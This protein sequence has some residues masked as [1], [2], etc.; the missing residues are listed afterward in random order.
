MYERIKSLEYS[1]QDYAF[2]Y[3]EKSEVGDDETIPFGLNHLYQGKNLNDFSSTY[4]SSNEGIIDVDAFGNVSGVKGIYNGNVK[5]D[6][7][8]SADV[9]ATI[10]ATMNQNGQDTF[11]KDL[12]FTKTFTYTG[13]ERA[14]PT[15]LSS[16]KESASFNKETRE[17]TLD[18]N[19]QFQLKSILNLPSSLTSITF[20]SSDDK[21]VSTTLLSLSDTINV[22]SI[23]ENSKKV[24][25]DLCG[26][27][28]T[29]R[30]MDG[31]TPK[32]ETLVF[33]IRVRKA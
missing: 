19:A 20:S 32:K 7:T 3:A 26:I 8:K 30:Y 5:D 9:E 18:E 29:V 33:Y 6:N 12:S 21:L 24:Q 27:K 11:K 31:L 14:F 25:R 23:Y 4:E 1:N 28:A 22:H 2:S 15:T 13:K 17:L 10:T 16:F